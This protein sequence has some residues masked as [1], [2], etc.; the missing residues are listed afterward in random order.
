MEKT[1]TTEYGILVNVCF[2]FICVYLYIKMFIIGIVAIIH[3]TNMCMVGD[4]VEIRHSVKSVVWSLLTQ[5]LAT[6]IF[7]FT[8]T[9]IVRVCACLHV[10][11]QYVLY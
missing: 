9:I 7:T 3:V 4:G 8:C 5:C 10:Y 6:G 1:T 11:Y 2:Q